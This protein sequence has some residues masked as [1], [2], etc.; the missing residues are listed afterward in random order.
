MFKKA[1]VLCPLCKTEKGVIKNYSYRGGWSGGAMVLDKLPG[2]G[3][4]T[5]L[6]T[7]R[8]RAYCSCS[9]CGWG[10][11]DIFTLIY[12]FSFLSPSLWETTRYR[13]KYCLKGSLSPKATNQPTLTEKNWLLMSKFFSKRVDPLTQRRSDQEGSSIVSLV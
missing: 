10:C 1:Q 12:P 3:R 8:A 2:P 6:D 11:L 7:S 13:L 9:R 5:S 4:P